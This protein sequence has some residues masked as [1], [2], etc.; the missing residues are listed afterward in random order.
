MIFHKIK[1]PLKMFLVRKAIFNDNFVTLCHRYVTTFFK[2]FFHT[3]WKNQW[4]KY[5][6]SNYNTAPFFASYRVPK[7]KKGWYQLKGQLDTFSFP[8]RNEWST[9]VFG[10]VCVCVYVHYVTIMFLTSGAYIIEE[11]SGSLFWFHIVI[12]FYVHLIT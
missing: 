6:F 7:W 9:C 10:Y 12:L 1:T 3:L 4:Y 2:V 11:G 8:M 5:R